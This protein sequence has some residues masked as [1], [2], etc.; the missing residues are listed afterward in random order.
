MGNI[1]AIRLLL[2][3]PWQDD[4]VH[5]CD[6]PYSSQARYLVL[7]GDVPVLTVSGKAEEKYNTKIE[8]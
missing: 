2:S 6:K 5:A 8:T 7:G 1:R 3:C 4:T